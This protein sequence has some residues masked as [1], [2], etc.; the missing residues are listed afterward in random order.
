MLV[1]SFQLSD[2]SSITQLL[3]NVLSEECYEETM[4]A[5][6]KQLSWDS[7]LVLVAVE[8]ER[9]AGVIIGTIDNNNG[10]YYRIAVEGEFQR[11]GIGK[12]MIEA[13]KTRFTQRK[14]RKILISVDTH[15]E[16]VLPVYESVGYRAEHFTRTTHQLSIVNG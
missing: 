4:S 16:M 7:E 1:R 5:F 11:K 14:V 13:M 3:E 10:Y 8:Q 2:Y 12:A 6:A 15:N 9:V